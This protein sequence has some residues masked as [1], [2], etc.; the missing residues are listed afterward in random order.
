MLTRVIPQRFVNRLFLTAVCILSFF[1]YGPLFA[2][3]SFDLHKKDF[4]SVLGFCEDQQVSEWM[5]QIS[6]K[7]IDGY[8]GVELPEYGGLNFYDY[9][10]SEFPGFKCKHRLL[11]H[12]GYNSRPWNDGLQ[13]KVNALPWGKDPAEVKRFQNALV[14]EQKRRN[15]EAN[16][17]TE[18]LFGFA[19]GGKDASYA[20]AMISVVYDVHL[21]GDYTPDNKDFDGVQDFRSVVGDLIDSVRKLDYEKSKP[22]VKKIQSVANDEALSV[23]VRA[24]KLLKLLSSDFPPFLKSAQDGALAAR[25]KKKGISFR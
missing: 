18:K 4:Y 16:D 10:K 6:S 9:L 11:F 7:M 22:L 8:R 23:H 24:E 15:A 20:N 19:S 21:L 25:F 5:R 12:W 2:H 13:A 3:S 1:S 17:M 14:K